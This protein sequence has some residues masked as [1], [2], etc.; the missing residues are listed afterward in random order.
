M[1]CF[2]GEIH[3]YFL[4][5]EIFFAGCIRYKFIALAKQ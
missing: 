2:S 4:Q 5:R 1:F 3:V